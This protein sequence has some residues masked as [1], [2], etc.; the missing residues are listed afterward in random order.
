M[1]AAISD[2]RIGI[3]DALNTLLG[4]R[5]YNDLPDTPITPCAITELKRVSY[6]T[7][8]ARGAD[9]FQF[10]IQVLSGR[11]DDR[12]AQTRIESYIAGSGTGSLKEALEAD[13]T[14]DGACMTL[15]VIEAGGLQ[16]YDRSDGMS[17]LGVEFQVLI[18]A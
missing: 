10:A 8:F 6:D 15:R 7:T 14:L 1:P 16:S 2:L 17:L 9:E 11:A 4:I 12:T 13:P 3:S 18:Y 5:V